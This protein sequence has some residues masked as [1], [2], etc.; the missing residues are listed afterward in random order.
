MKHLVL[1]SECREWRC[2]L[3]ELVHHLPVVGSQPKEAADVNA[4][5]LALPLLDCV[6]LLLVHAQALCREDVPKES[7][8]PA[9]EGTHLACLANSWW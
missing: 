8:L 6:Y 5:G 4:L 2:H 3:I 7:Y 1:A 9:A